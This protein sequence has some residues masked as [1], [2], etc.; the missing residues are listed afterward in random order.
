MNWLKK[1]HQQRLNRLNRRLLWFMRLFIRPIVGFSVTNG[2]FSKTLSDKDKNFQVCSDENGHF[3]KKKSFLNQNNFFQLHFGCFQNFE[4]ESNLN[5]TRNVKLTSARLTQSVAT[6]EKL[7][8]SSAHCSEV[9]CAFHNI[10]RNCKYP[11]I[12]MLYTNR[13]KSN[14]T[15]SLSITNQLAFLI[16][17]EISEK[18]HW[19]SDNFGY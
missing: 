11:H 9:F 15:D 19:G 13:L 3:E 12:F 1:T 8:I 7:K 14:L 17:S 4:S 18:H 10:Q 16:V 5:V 6:A 2:I